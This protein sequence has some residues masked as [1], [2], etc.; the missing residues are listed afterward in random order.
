MQ[1]IHDNVIG[2]ADYMAAFTHKTTDNFTKIAEHNLHL[3]V[4]E[5]WQ[6]KLKKTAEQFNNNNSIAVLGVNGDFPGILESLDED[7]GEY[8]KFKSDPKPRE[9]FKFLQQLT[10]KKLKN[11]YQLGIWKPVRP[12]PA[13]GFSNSRDAGEHITVEGPKLVKFMYAAYLENIKSAATKWM[14]L[15]DPKKKLINRIR[16]ENKEQGFMKIGRE[17]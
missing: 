17:F 4:F 15:N 2:D 9:E 3:K 5:D 6:A 7:L 13:L 11:A 14:R 12:Y 16:N 10:E 8:I 1:N